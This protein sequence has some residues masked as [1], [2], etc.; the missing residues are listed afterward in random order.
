ME[1]PR[2]GIIRVQGCVGGE[3]VTVDVPLEPG[4][5][6]KEITEAEHQTWVKYF[7]AEDW[8]I[9]MTQSQPYFIPESEDSENL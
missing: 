9:D 3:M 1:V 4:Y 7:V 6:H 8:T 5:S 2:E